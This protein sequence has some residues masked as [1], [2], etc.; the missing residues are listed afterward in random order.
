MIKYLFFIL[1]FIFE[2]GNSQILKPFDNEKCQYFS[3]KIKGNEAVKFEFLSEEDYNNLKSK[4]IKLNPIFNLENQNLLSEFKTK[5]PKVFQDSCATFSFY[6]NNKLR[7]SKSCNIK[8]LLVDKKS[9]YYIFKMA[10][11]EISGFLLFNE[12]TKISQVTDGFPQILENGKYIASFDNG[13]N[14][15]TINFYKKS[16]KN[17]N[18]YELNITPRFRIDEYNLYKNPYGNFDVFIAV[19]SKSLKLI[20]EG[21]NGKK[22]ELDENNG[23]N[24]KLKISY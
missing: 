14:S 13:L 24:L 8:F 22:Y 23:C 21:K 15:T 4:K 6:E 5:F 17:F 16:E 7:K 3:Y 19:S 9:D 1:S 18:E 10:G 11:F 20:E 2:M 12:K